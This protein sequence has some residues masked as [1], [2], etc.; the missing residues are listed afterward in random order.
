MT[1]VRIDAADCSGTCD[2]I[3]LINWFAVHPTSM[4]NTNR[5]VSGDNK[6]YAAQLFEKEMNPGMRM[7]TGKF[8]AAFGSSNLG[9]VSPN[10]RG[11]RCID[12]DLECDYA[13]STCPPNNLTANCIAFGPGKDFDMK[14]ST[15]I[16][17]EKQYMKAKELF[18]NLPNKIL[19]SGSTGFAHQYINMSNYVV[20][21]PVVFLLL[22]YTLSALRWTVCT[23]LHH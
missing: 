7:G 3:G 14:D 11:A 8:V 21:G 18:E 2:P 17:G 19:V 15:R 12:T 10:T 22:F 6:G 5:L 16:I 20:S 9:D 13:T 4:N 1:L 23:V